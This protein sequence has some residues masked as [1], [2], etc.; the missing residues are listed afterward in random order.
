MIRHLS[1]RVPI[2][3]YRLLDFIVPPSSVPQDSLGE[4]LTQFRPVH[5]PLT[6]WN[7]RNVFV[8]SK[9]SLPCLPRDESG[10]IFSKY[11]I[12]LS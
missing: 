4:Y 12:F 5:E 2:T 10:G 1:L 9:L 7:L 3:L 6:L 11:M 8:L